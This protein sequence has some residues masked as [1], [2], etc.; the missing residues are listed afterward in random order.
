MPKSIS[1]NR[2]IPAP[3]A[4]IFAVLT[5]PALHPVIDGSGTVVAPKGGHQETLALGSAFSM[6]MRMGV[7]YT[8]KNRVVEFEDDR[9]IAWTHVGGYRWR[10]EL[11][12]VDGATRVTETFDWAPSRMGWAVELAGFPQKIV[13]DLV[14][15]LK[16]LEEYVTAD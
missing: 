8:M 2:L 15:T 11:E 4:A 5:N 1:A 14:A 6:G 12:P 10:Y 9:L 16:R 7:P 3:A 13:P